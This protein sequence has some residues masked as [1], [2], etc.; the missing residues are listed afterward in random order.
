[1]SSS[2]SGLDASLAY[3]IIHRRQTLQFALNQ[4]GIRPGYIGAESR[5]ILPLLRD[6]S[7][8]AAAYQNK[9]GNQPEQ[10]FMADLSYLGVTT[11]DMIEKRIAFL[12]SSN[13]GNN[14]IMDH[15]GI[16]EDPSKFAAPGSRKSVQLEKLVKIAK[17]KKTSKPKKTL[18]DI[19][20]ARR[21]ALYE[22]LKSDFPDSLPSD[23]DLIHHIANK[24][25][26]FM[27]EYYFGISPKTLTTDYFK[28]RKKNGLVRKRVYPKHEGLLKNRETELMELLSQDMT[29]KN[30]ERHMNLSKGDG[31]SYLSKIY[32][33]YKI[34]DGVNHRMYVL[35]EY[36]KSRGEKIE[37]SPF[38]LDILTLRENQIAA[39]AREG[40]ND[41]SIGSELGIHN[42]TVGSQLTRIFSKLGIPKSILH[43]R[44]ALPEYIAKAIEEQKNHKNDPEPDKS[45]E[46]TPKEVQVFEQ[47]CTTK[48]YEEMAREL[49]LTEGTLK[50]YRNSVYLKHDIPKNMNP[51][52][53]LISSYRDSHKIFPSEQKSKAALNRKKSLSFYEDWA[54]LLAVSGLSNASIANEMGTSTE[55]IKNHLSYAF[56]KLGIPED[57]KDK[58]AALFDYYPL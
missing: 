36:N 41:A 30:A 29:M 4:L 3:P 17:E 39:L 21:D 8:L 33:K 50:A 58:R 6:Y 44:Q 14:E 46:L 35:N 34:P 9:N 42:N 54:V 28:V 18:H 37:S 24:R 53:Y 1:M 11:R 48:R 2:S 52:M 49:N 57:R 12:R 23:E 7:A 38:H 55:S 51:R 13:Y 32:A 47:L 22:L 5:D 31:I 26:D 27:K 25:F 16:S 19:V 10:D 15:L 45:K 20:P 40:R 43:K 56:D